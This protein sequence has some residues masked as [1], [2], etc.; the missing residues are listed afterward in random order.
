MGWPIFERAG[1]LADSVVGLL[2][3]RLSLFGLEFQEEV[4]RLLGH[5]ALLLLAFLLG[6]LA[7]LCAT[8]ALLILAASHDWLLQASLLLAGGYALLGLL[9]AFLLWRRVT[10][11]PLPFAATRA[12]FER[13]QAC[14]YPQQETG[15]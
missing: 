9:C 7:F 8:A 1:R 3:N 12:E 13:D 14:L 10:Q 15:S 11:A 6:A 2:G 4:E 5:V